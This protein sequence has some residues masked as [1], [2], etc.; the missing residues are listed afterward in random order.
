MIFKK[1]R[2]TYK[3]IAAILLLLFCFEA[4]QAQS[5]PVEIMGGHKRSGVDV[6][7]F[8]NFS[9]L[10]STAS[11]WLFFHRT[12]ASSNYHGQ[13]SFGVRNALS[14]NFKKG[15][16]IVV[17]VQLLQSGVAAKG[18]IQFVK[19]FERASLFSWVVAGNNTDHFASADWFV[20]LRW[21]PIIKNNWNWF[22][23]LE[24]LSSMDIESN[25]NLV[26]RVRL[27][28]GKKSWQFG[29]ASDQTQTGNTNLIATGNNGFFYER[30][31]SNFCFQCK[32]FKTTIMIAEQVTATQKVANRFNELAK[33]GQFDKIQDELYAADAV[34]IE[35]KG[36]PGMISVDGLPAIKNK[37]VVFNQMVEEMHGGYSS[38]PIVAGNHFSVAMGMDVTMKGAGR[39]KMDEIAVYEVKDGKIVKEHFFF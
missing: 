33:A 32:Q 29:L 37:G 25:K 24:L 3:G 12:R 23:Q 5:L 9:S 7:W 18:G 1:G 10:K 13:T 8:R 16:G 14:Y 38:D 22:T 30:N 17:T 28:L 6:L 15:I 2:K 11:P 35:P 27:G 39:M 19:V 34:S 21:T 31:F 20:L 4:I 36:A 26:Q